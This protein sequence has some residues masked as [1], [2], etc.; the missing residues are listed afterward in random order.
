MFDVPATMLSDYE[1]VIAGLCS[2]LW[3]INPHYYELKSQF[4]QCCGAKISE[5]QQTT[6][7]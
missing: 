6:K 1:E 2:P 5:L 7:S 4:S 3:D